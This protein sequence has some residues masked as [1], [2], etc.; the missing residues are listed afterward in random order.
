MYFEFDPAPYEKQLARELTNLDLVNLTISP[1][2]SLQQRSSE[3][4]RKEEAVRR[5]IRGNLHRLGGG[6]SKQVIVPIGE[7]GTIGRGPSR[8]R[9]LG[10]RRDPGISV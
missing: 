5:N 3:P 7:F 6:I 4:R 2:W 8:E 10:S 9:A 1:R